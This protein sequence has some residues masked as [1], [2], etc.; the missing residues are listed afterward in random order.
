M[1]YNGQS[2]KYR[3]QKPQV[4]VIESE[5]FHLRLL[6]SLH[7]RNHSFLSPSPTDDGERNE[8]YLTVGSDDEVI[9][10]S[11][12]LSLCVVSFFNPLEYLTLIRIRRHN[13]PTTGL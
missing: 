4:E 7:R 9:T 3:G 2:A 5:H 8:L 1:T 11:N 10:A 12:Y 13:L 6:R